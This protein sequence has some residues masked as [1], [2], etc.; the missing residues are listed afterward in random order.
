VPR[1][2]LLEIDVLRRAAS[3][4]RPAHHQIC[5]ASKTFKMLMHAAR[6]K[7]WCMRLL[8]VRSIRSYLSPNELIRAGEKN[9]GSLLFPLLSTCI[10]TIC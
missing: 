9:I 4:E 1:G 10:G 8:N 2:R 6:G 7:F 3:G 5:H